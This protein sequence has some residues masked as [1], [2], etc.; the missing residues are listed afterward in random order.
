MPTFEKAHAFTNHWTSDDAKLPRDDREFQRE[1][2]GEWKDHADAMAYAATAK[3]PVT[4]KHR[5]ALCDEVIACDMKLV[6]SYV[7]ATE[8]HH[9]VCS[10]RPIEVGDHVRWEYPARGTWAEGDVTAW[11]PKHHAE[12]AVYDC[13]TIRVAAHCGSWP[14]C[15]DDPVVTGRE[16]RFG[17]EAR[18]G[19]VVRR[20]PRPAAAQATIR[21]A[22]GD[23]KITADPTLKPGEMRVERPKVGDRIPLETGARRVFP[24]G[25]DRSKPC[26]TCTRP[27]GEHFGVACSMPRMEG[28]QTG[29]VCAPVCQ[30]GAHAVPKY[31]PVVVD[32]AAMERAMKDEKLMQR[33]QEEAEK[34]IQ[35]L[36]TGGTK[37]HTLESP[38]PALV[39]GLDREV[40]LARWMENR[41][42]VETRCA[43]PNAMTRMQRD[44]GREM[45]LQRF[46]VARSVELRGMVDA[47]RAAERNRVTY[48][49]VD[50]DD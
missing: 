36:V 17:C 18:D 5:C 11:M 35:W 29:P 28:Y 39:D 13:V 38:A 30:C 16:H 42:A 26:P 6:E 10:K 20:I 3:R 9:A 47:D 2:L 21:T 12:G 7:T 1:Y 46:G 37:V 8:A 44:V 33:V 31:R 48:C 19:I 14:N 34:R 22:F 50:C 41:L 43:P 32:K 40:C 24:R 15:G 27:L 45:W 49:E 4:T 25:A 23:I